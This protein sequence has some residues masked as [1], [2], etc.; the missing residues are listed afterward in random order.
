MDAANELR[1]D[2]ATALIAKISAFPYRY[3]EEA[4]RLLRFYHNWSPYSHLNASKLDVFAPALLRL[5]EKSPST[6]ASGDISAIVQNWITGLLHLSLY[7]DRIWVPDPAEL[8]AQN[9]LPYETLGLHDPL[10]GDPT[11]ALRAAYA[12][13]ALQPLV[14]KG[15][16]ALYPAITLYKKSVAMELFGENRFYRLDEVLTSWPDLYIAEGLL[17][18]R[19]FGAHYTALHN[20]EFEALK[21]AGEQIA[22]QIGVL[23]QRIVASLPRWKLPY[24]E[25][26]SAEVLV[27]ARANEEAFEDFRKLIRE[28]GSK[29]VAGLEDVNFD[30]EN[31][32]LERDY[33]T[34][35][36]RNLN[37]QVKGISTLR[38]HASEAGIDFTA[39]AIAGLVLTGGIADSFLTGGANVLAKV[40]VK[41]FTVR[42]APR[43]SAE[44]VYAFHTG[45]PMGT[46]FGMKMPRWF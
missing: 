39:G 6:V 30:L 42:K 26:L 31:Q 41:I 25:G 43:A 1:R 14:E 45:R 19:E 15:V 18:A 40:L 10:L 17:Y 12:M 3:S 37:A 20:Q 29:L 24:F 16:I 32:R 2:L 34:P 7:V 27:Q 11:A 4:E 9:L 23:D 22:K 35:T 8:L 28:M 5:Q 44:L 13:E 38:E 33:L 36:L 46:S 21:L